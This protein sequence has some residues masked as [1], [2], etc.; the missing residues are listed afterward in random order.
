MRVIIGPDDNGAV[1]T[2]GALVMMRRRTRGED[3][4]QGSQ[5]RCRHRTRPP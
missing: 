4:Q 5:K 2:V 1:A 3:G